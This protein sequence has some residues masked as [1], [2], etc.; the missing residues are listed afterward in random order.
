MSSATFTLSAFGDE[1]ARDLDEQCET[2]NRL[3][4][5]H[6]DLRTAWGKNVV[7]LDDD[8]VARVERT[9]RQHGIAIAC[10]GS[11]VGK[12]PIAD[13][14]DVELANMARLFAIGEA[15]DCRRLRLFSFY[16]PDT[17]TNVHHDQHVDESVSRLRALTDLAQ[18]KGFVLLL[19]NERDIV[20]DTIA[21]CHTLLEAVDSPVLRFLWDP[22]N[23]VLVGEAEPT[24][25]GWPLLGDR[26][27][28]V[29]I[30]DA[31]L[32][33]GTICPAGEG[34]GQVGELLANLRDAGYQGILAL[35][36][37]LAIAGQRGGFSGPDGMARAVGA[38]RDL[39][40]ATGCVETRE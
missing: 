38:L 40:A 11:P 16:P 36:P 12:S 37:H 17:S 26:I 20:G 8:D 22:A 21:R 32:S 9:C 31:H 34:D 27:G 29:H 3:E 5:A 6:L 1:I 23:F 7:T 28:G 30:K 35:E 15:L 13:P 19:E 18:S 10:L 4:I 2:L 39:M 24:T 33:D 14:L 25:C